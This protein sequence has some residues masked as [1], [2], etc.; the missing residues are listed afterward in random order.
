MCALQ[1]G[2]PTFVLSGNETGV[3]TFPDQS[4]LVLNFTDV[5]R[6]YNAFSQTLLII[7]GPTLASVLTPP[8][9][10]VTST[11]DLEAAVVDPNN[12][13][14]VRGFVHHE[15]GWYYQGGYK[16]VAR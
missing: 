12:S 9:K 5:L 15:H 4:T 14:F 1:L 8:F 7:E 6:G 2:V 3:A 13:S 16:C 11:W 10:P